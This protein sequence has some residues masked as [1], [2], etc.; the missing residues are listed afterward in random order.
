MKKYYLKISRY[1]EKFHDL[2]LDITLE[3]DLAIK[4]PKRNDED[5]KIVIPSMLPEFQKG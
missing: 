3:C 1:E 2:L 5:E 4:F